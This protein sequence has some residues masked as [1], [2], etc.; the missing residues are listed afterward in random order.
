MIILSI[1]KAKNLNKIILEYFEILKR[2]LIDKQSNFREEIYL[3]IIIRNKV[4]YI[5]NDIFKYK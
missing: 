4:Y 1:I 5:Y 3:E 2:E